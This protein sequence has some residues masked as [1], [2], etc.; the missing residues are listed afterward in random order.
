[1]PGLYVDIDERGAILFGERGGKLICVDGHH[2]SCNARVVTHVHADHIIGL[3]SCISR[4]RPIIAT[5]ITHA[6]LKALGYSVPDSRRIE[7]NYGQSI[8]LDNYT[9][10]LEYSHHIP[11]SSQ[12]VVYDNN[13]GTIAAYTSDFKSPGKRTPILKDVDVLVLDATYGDPSNRR[14]NEEEVINAL[15]QLTSNLLR[16]GPL[17]LYAYYGKAQEVMQILRAEGI[18][19]PFIL[20]ENQWKV[21]KALKEFGYEVRDV[22]AERSREVAE[23]LRDG[24]FIY[25]AHFNSPKSYINR[26]FEVKN[27]V[28][29]SGWLFNVFVRELK[30]HLWVVAF[31]DHADFD[32]L[33]EYVSISKPKLLILD[34]Y[35]NGEN[36]IKFSRYVESVLKIE[37]LIMPKSKASM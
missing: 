18:D 22:Y 23:L 20:S 24:W 9:I 13:G 6:I 31:S 14:A 16:E 33:I 21:Y 25:V 15:V 3:N 7:L 10:R 17:A 32:E 27:H 11:G 37:T 34:A 35:R 29:L 1:V 30:P 4:L 19:A 28:V 5:P 26:R 8:T 36:A 2:P 12:V